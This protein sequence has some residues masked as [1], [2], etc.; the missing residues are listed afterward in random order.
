MVALEAAPTHD[1]K[2]TLDDQQVLDFCTRGFHVLEGAIDAE[3]NARTLEVRSGSGWVGPP[4][5]A[6]RE[7]HFHRSAAPRPHLV[8]VHPQH[9]DR[10]VTGPGGGAYGLE[11]LGW[12]QDHML[13]APALAGA[14]R[15]LLGQGF[16]LPTMLSSHLGECPADASGWCVCDPLRA[17][18]LPP[19]SCAVG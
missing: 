4:G 16:G 14:V 17:D 18:P 5:A 3:T 15:S 13:R 10:H 11:E 7:L 6:A 8:R 12:F 9:L 19:S 2:P 1:C